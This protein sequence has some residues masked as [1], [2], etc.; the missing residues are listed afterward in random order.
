MDFERF[1]EKTKSYVQQAQ[2]LAMRSKH[3]SL[4]PEHLLKVM[5]DDSEGTAVRL[6]QAAQ[7]GNCV[8]DG[9]L[10]YEHGLEAPGQRRVLFDVLAVLIECRCTNHMQFAPRQRRFQHIPGIHRA[11]G[12]ARTDQRMELIEEKYYFS[13]T[14]LDFIKYRLK[15]LLEIPPGISPL[16]ARRPDRGSSA[17]CF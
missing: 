12:F 5:L 6:I 13:V 8:L 14:C 9:R 11:L 7:N 1:T 17:A 2:T 3:Q 10:G 4:E 16:P 15:T